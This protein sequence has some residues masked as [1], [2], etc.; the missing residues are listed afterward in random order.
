MPITWPRCLGRGTPIDSFQ[1][2]LPAP[3]SI[4][5]NT[6]E[7]PSLEALTKPE[8]GYEASVSSALSS[9]TDLSEGLNTGQTMILTPSLF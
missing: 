6:L 9:N 2:P 4:S 1:P 8:S 7:P 5:S 3:S